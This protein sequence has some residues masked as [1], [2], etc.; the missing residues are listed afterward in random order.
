MAL[1]EYTDILTYT[2]NMSLY[3]Q[4]QK[5]GDTEAANR[6]KQSAS[7]TM[8]GADI[9]GDS[10]ENLSLSV[11]KRKREH[12]KAM[13][14]APEEE[15]E[16]ILS[17]APRLERRIFQ[18]AWGMDVEKKPDLVD[19]FSNHELPDAGSEVWHPNTNMEHVKIK[20]GQ[21]MGVDLSQMGYYP[22]QL[23]EA[24]L[25]NPAYP[26]FNQSSSQDSVLEKLKRMMLD[27]GLTGSVSPV[28][29]PY[30]SN[31]IDMSV[32]VR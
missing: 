8:Y 21:N 12:F 28:Y 32:G 19:Y 24:N 20:I 14:G 22:Q 2:K 3:S 9:Y 26:S 16:R 13:I 27:N 25:V 6:F 31:S 18:A 11:P 4:A 30:A 1:E 29:T 17:T 23:K 15:R 7:R 5:A 10:I